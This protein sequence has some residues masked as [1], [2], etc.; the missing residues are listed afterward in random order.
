MPSD[1]VQETKGIEGRLHVDHPE[2]EEVHESS[3]ESRVGMHGVSF[4]PSAGRHENE[5]SLAPPQVQVQRSLIQR[6]S[7]GPRNPIAGWKAGSGVFH[8]GIPENARREPGWERNNTRAQDLDSQ[9]LR[10]WPE[11][12]VLFRH[13]DGC[14][15]C[16]TEQEKSVNSR[17]GP[18]PLRKPPG[19]GA[20]TPR[21]PRSGSGPEGP[22]PG[23]AAGSRG[24][25]LPGPR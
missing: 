11:P 22:S 24:R 23:L 1:H 14:G 21:L 6:L 5:P 10:P 18:G 17:W 9:D 2:L 3:A 15:S 20:P 4:A 8:S 16:A 7:A 13:R 19:A 12:P 25:W